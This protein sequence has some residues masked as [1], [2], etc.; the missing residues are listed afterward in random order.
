MSHP[1]GR[2][3]VWAGP[4][5]TVNRVGDRYFDQLAR[6]GHDSRPGDIDLLAGL[7]VKAVRYPV[8]W[9]RHGGGPI[10]WGWADDRLGRLRELGVRP[11][12]GLVHHGSGPPHTSL[13]DGAF[14]DG[15]AS[16]GARVAGRFPWIEAFTPVNEPLTTARFSGLYGHW[17]PHG[18][19]AATFA[20]CLL[21]QCRAVV[22]AMRAIRRVNPGAALV[23]TEDFGKTHASPRLRYQADF[24]NERR[25]LTWDLLCGRVDRHHPMWSYFDWAGIPEAEVLWFAENPCPPD[26]LGVNHYVTSE[27]YL[28]GRLARYPA[29]MHGSNGI[30]RY[31][32]T[33]A[34]RVLQKGGEGPYRLLGQVWERYR[35]PIA[36]TEVHL[37]CTPDEQVR[38]LWEM[39]RAATRL[40]DEGADV[41]AVT[42]W[43]VFGAYDWDSLVTR[44]ADR[45]EAGAFDV[46]EDPP[47]PTAVAELIRDLAAGRTPSDP[48][49]ETVG[50]WRR[51]ERLLAHAR[52]DRRALCP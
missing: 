5:C 43:S 34:L 21:A 9:E 4:E 16:F 49:L 51:P 25:W 15:L 26:L 24:E 10:D 6:T 28:D 50:W 44:S 42:A 30:H 40:R 48:A 22:L 31:V 33:E 11:I 29:E 37:A 52:K 45:Y 46:S 2:P 7:G 20:R 41:R 12:V 14:A 32:D 8:L 1:N 39:W 23:Q 17:Y 13:I 36:V 27:R 18:L 19:D 47:R 35:L 38:W 3:E